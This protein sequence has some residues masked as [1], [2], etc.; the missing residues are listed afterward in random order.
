MFRNAT[1]LGKIKVM[2]TTPDRSVA[3]I[4]KESQKGP[5]VKGD[6]VGSNISITG[7]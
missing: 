6:K 5:I 2:K 7:K 4:I 1:Y 3:A